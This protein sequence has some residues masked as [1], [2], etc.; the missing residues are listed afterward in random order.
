[1]LLCGSDPYAVLGVSS[2]FKRKPDLVAGG[3]TNTS[4]GIE[5]TEKLTG[6]KALNLLDK[7]A[8][9]KLAK[10]IVDKIESWQAPEV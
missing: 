2:A 7:N 3:A 10:M 8:I 5:L 4:A 9:P 6:I 1:M